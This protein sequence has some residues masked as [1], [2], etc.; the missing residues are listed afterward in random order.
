MKNNILLFSLIV[1]A[2]SINAQDSPSEK[3]NF[4]HQDTLRGSITP[5]RAW[6]DLTYY[7]LDIK[8]N[9]DEKYISGKT[10]TSTGIKEKSQYSEINRK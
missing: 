8:V 1:A 6:W 2:L 10:E 9:P 5:E 4:T 7:N 3:L